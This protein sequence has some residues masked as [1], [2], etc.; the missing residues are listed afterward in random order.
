MCVCNGG[1]RDLKTCVNSRMLQRWLK[2][3]GLTVLSHRRSR[4]K[5][6]QS[7][8]V[9]L[10]E[11]SDQMDWWRCSWTMAALTFNLMQLRP[12]SLPAVLKWCVFHYNIVS[13]SLKT[14]VLRV[15]FVI[16]SLAY[17]T[18]YEHG[19]LYIVDHRFSSLI[20]PNCMDDH[21][22]ISVMLRDK[23]SEK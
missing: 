11:P 13:R 5:P 16:V 12:S 20:I 6:S 21:E 10:C 8:M 1:S 19:V 4:F 7:H 22:L 17:L 3:S 2:I 14:I 15:H 23:A 18:F 9:K